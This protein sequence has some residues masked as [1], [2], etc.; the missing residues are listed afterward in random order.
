[1]LTDPATARSLI[2][3]VPDVLLSALVASALTLIGTLGGVIA[4][5]W[6]NT[7]RLKLQLDHDTSEKAK[8][9]LA[10]LRRDLYLN[11]AAAI[12]RGLAYFGSLP[13]ADL[14]KP[15]ADEPMRDVLAV[16]AQLQLVVTQGTAELLS[17]L[18]AT[19]G[20]LQM[21]LVARVLPIHKLRSDINIRTEHY[22]NAQL[23]IR[24][25]LAGMTA[26][27]ES[28]L[29]EPGQFERLNRSAKFAMDLARKYSDER[30]H[31]WNQRNALSRKFL[32][33]LLPDLKILAELQTRVMV[34]LRRDLDVGGDIEVFMAIMRRQLER[35]EQAVDAF[36]RQVFGDPDPPQE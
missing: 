16:G 4:T 18:I 13:Q 12:V 31:F 24:R 26:Y 10:T 8:E 11:A 22:D 21:K 32:K 30:D 34:E 5:N 1:M 23:E 9:R 25:A 27:N 3:G 33:D 36:D 14:T 35:V 2:Q 28:D 29:N 7:G 20:E 15:G 17:D 6:G 19:Y